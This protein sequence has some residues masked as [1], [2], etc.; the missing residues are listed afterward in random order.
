[1]LGKLKKIEKAHQILDYT[2]SFE[3]RIVLILFTKGESF[4]AGLEEI[5]TR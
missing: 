1:M 2:W 3:S 5:Y 4:R